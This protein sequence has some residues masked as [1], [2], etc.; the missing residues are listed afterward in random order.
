MFTRPG[1]RDPRQAQRVLV[2]EE[3]EALF[4]GLELLEGKIV[5]DDAAPEPSAH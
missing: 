2:L 3:E 5:C 1:R 4:P